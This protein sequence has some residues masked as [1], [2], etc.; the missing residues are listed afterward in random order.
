[1]KNPGENIA[2]V[3][4]FTI[5]VDTREQ[6][7]FR[8]TG[9]RAGSGQNAGVIAVAVE[10]KHLPT[11]DYS[12]VGYENRIAVERKSKAD[13]FMSVGAERNRFQREIE[14]LNEFE[15]GA[16]V[17]EAD[18]ATLLHVPPFRTKMRPEAVE[19]TILSWST[20]YPKVH[21]FP[22]THRQ[23]AEWV[24]FRLL[25]FWWRHFVVEAEN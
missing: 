10:R 1:M 12:I 14:R 19:A 5:A 25:D 4:P 23:H 17:I 22:C 11:G 16:V 8:F 24:T 18:F 21:W 9:L 15:F 6:A 3:C 13:L 2:R 20:R 7:P